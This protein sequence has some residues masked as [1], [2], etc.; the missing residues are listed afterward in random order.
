MKAQLTANSPT[1]VTKLRFSGAAS[2]D[3]A[4]WTNDEGDDD[5]DDEVEEKP[6]LDSDSSPSG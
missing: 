1:A 6:P 4:F 2:P 5:D 3:T